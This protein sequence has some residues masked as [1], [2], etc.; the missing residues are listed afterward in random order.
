[1]SADNTKIYKLSSVVDNFLVENDLNNSWFPKM[2]VW[3]MRGLREI[4]LDTFQQA[5]S[6]HF[7]ITGTKTVVLPAGFVDFIIISGYHNGRCDTWCVNSDLDILPR[8]LGPTASQDGF[9]E[10]GYWLHGCDVFSY[11]KPRYSR[12]SFKVHDTGGVKILTMDV[13]TRVPE[14]YLEWVGDGINLCSETIIH[15]YLYDWLTKYME[16]QYEEKSNK[17]ATLSS[18]DRKLEMLHYAE[19]RLRSRTSNLDPETLISLAR[20]YTTLANKV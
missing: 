5:Q 2:L 20:Q 10:V 15:P 1:M 13:S 16:Y 8:S 18:I 17:L 11:G 14:I 3:A 4:S 19:K 9:S 7:P 6:D 12:D